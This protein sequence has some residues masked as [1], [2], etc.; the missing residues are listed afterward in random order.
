[1]ILVRRPITLIKTYLAFSASI[2]NHL[3]LSDRILEAQKMNPARPIIKQSMELAPA[4]FLL[5][6][7]ELAIIRQRLS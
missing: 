5:E 2:L 4:H 6:A 1:M 7:W 3:K